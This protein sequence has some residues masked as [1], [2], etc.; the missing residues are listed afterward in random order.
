[1]YIQK[2]QLKKKKKINNQI[3][4]NLNKY[5]FTNDIYKDKIYVFNRTQ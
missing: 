2:T 5:I 1:M 3:V 4:L